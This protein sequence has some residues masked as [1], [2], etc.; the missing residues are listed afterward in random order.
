MALIQ[1][2]ALEGRITERLLRARTDKK[3]AEG[4]ASLGE[5]A[6]DHGPEPLVFDVDLVKV[7]VRTTG[8]SV[9]RA[10][11]LYRAVMKV[12]EDELESLRLEFVEQSEAQGL[13]QLEAEELWLKLT[14]GVGLVTNKARAVA[15]ALTIL[16]A[17][18]LKAR[19]PRHYT[20]A[21]L[22]SQIR[23]H[24]MLAVHVE[25][26]RREGIKVLPPDVNASEVEFSVETGGVR[27]GLA[28]IR[29][30]SPTTATAIVQTRREMGPFRSIVELCATIGLEHL[31]KRALTA[32]IKAGALDSFGYNRSR[33]VEML[34][35]IMEEVRLG[36]MTLFNRTDGDAQAVLSSPAE[37]EV[38]E[39]S[40]LAQEKEVLGFYV[41]SHP[42]SKYGPLLES[43]APGGMG[44]LQ[45]LSSGSQVRVGGIVE[46]I[47]IRSSR[48]GEPIYFLRLEQLHGSVDVLVFL[49]VYA[50][51]EAYIK[52]GAL[53]L[54][55]GR[56]S[57][58]GVRLR[59]IVDQIMLLE[60]AAVHLAKSVHLHLQAEGLSQQGLSE[61][62]RLVASEP[63][64]SPVYLHIHIGR[65]T[66]VVHKLP[67][68][69]AVSPTME[70]RAEL[71]GTFGEDCVEI[72]Y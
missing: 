67:L 33:L 71:A 14:S 28:A 49:D 47:R 25:S 20:A 15:R 70:L 30:V 32:I 2:P 55:D 61:L 34:P 63:G 66:E 51:Y 43:I 65:Q 21:F 11:Q 42:L 6:L 8:R 53:V 37:A 54:V 35:A 57:R 64:S 39:S 10:D 60:K 38:D 9:Q 16:H 26:C 12:Q 19:F 59:L 17:V 69:R 68:T 22:S 56:V 45:R 40:R 44:D 4:R 58:E 1:P 72:R 41:T 62:Q 27:V 29:Q 52:K 18:E 7:I 46:Q 23:Q 50:D 13:K 3:T 31:G 24:D 48:K 36:Q 5:L